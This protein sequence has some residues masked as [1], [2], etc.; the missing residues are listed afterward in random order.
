MHQRLLTK[1]LTR[2]KPFCVLGATGVG[3]TMLLKDFSGQFSN[4]VHLDLNTVV[5]RAIF[6]FEVS[7]KETLKA[8]S[9][10]KG[11]EIRGSGTLIVL[12]EIGR[13]P[14]A[15][16]WAAA[17]AGEQKTGQTDAQTS[18]QMRGQPLVA[19]TSSVMTKELELLLNRENG[20]LTPYYLNPFSFEIGRAHV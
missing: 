7:A 3:K 16:R 20:K 10:L 17:L 5:D 4:S 8:I 6:N 13:C 15:I 18:G 1:S 19:A 14:E 2:S 9:F 12:D 11:R